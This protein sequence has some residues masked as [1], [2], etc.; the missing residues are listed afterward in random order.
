MDFSMLARQPVPILIH[1][2]TVIPA[3]FI[4]S[5]LIFFSKKGGRGHRALG[6]IYLSLMTI[7][8]T[9][10]IFIKSLNPG[11]FSWFHLFVPLTFWGVFAAI[12]RIRAR[13]VAGHRAAMLGLYFGGLVFAGALTFVP[14]RLMHRLFFGSPRTHAVAASSLVITG[15]R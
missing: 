7:T 8:A 3:F 6:T 5:W 1:L 15:Q 4:G 10:A 11:H 13:D 2:A 9:A 12:W 14:G